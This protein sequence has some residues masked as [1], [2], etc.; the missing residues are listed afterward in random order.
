[1]LDVRNQTI[2]LA[3]QIIWYFIDGYVARVN[4]VPTEDSE[5]YI[6]YHVHFRDNNYDMLFWKSLK[7]DN[8]WIE[9]PSSSVNVRRQKKLLL[10]CSYADYLAACKEEMPERWLKTYHKLA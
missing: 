8:W 6:N 3:A 5:D 2:Q 1:M 7:T 10:P 9:V 4:D